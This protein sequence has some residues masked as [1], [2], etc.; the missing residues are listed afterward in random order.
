[1]PFYHNTTVCLG[2]CLSI[3][4]FPFTKLHVYF[5]K[6]VRTHFIKE[7]FHL[8]YDVKKHGFSSCSSGWIDMGN[9]SKHMVFLQCEYTYVTEGFLSEQIGEDI[10]DKHT[11]SPQCEHIYEP[12]DLCSCLSYKDNTDSGTTC[13]LS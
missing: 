9:M 2:Y 1:M 3:S 5:T 4:S 12:L 8:M 7:T 10:V 11:A 13:C 6:N